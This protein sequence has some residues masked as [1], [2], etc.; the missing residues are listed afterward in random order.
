MAKGIESAEAHAIV[1]GEEGDRPMEPV[2]QPPEINASEKPT[3]LSQ[4][5]PTPSRAR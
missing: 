4:A 2:E 5:T 3:I 1:E